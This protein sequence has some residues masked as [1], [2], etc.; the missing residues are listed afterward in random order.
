MPAIYIGRKKGLDI[1]ERLCTAELL[2]GEAHVT[3]MAILP[4]NKLA[5]H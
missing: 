5:V 2:N 4:G 3:S 1:F